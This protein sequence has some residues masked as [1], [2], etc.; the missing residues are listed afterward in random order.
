MVRANL[1]CL[2]LRS[3]RCFILSA[4]SFAGEAVAERDGETE[5]AGE[6]VAVRAGDG[7]GVSGVGTGVCA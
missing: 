2:N 1:P 5:A 7:V 4:N 3:T 6:A